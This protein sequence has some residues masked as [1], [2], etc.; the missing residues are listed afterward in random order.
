MNIYDHDPAKGGKLIKSFTGCRTVGSP[1][2][3]DVDGSGLF[4]RVSTEVAFGLDAD[5]E[6]ETLTE[7]F[8]PTEGILIDTRIGDELTGADLFGDQGGPWADGY[9][10]LARL[11]ANADGWVDGAALERPALWIDANGNVKTQ[12]RRGV[13]AGGARRVCPVQDP[14][15]FRLDR[16]VDRWIEHGTED[17]RLSISTPVGAQATSLRQAGLLAGAA[18]AI[19]AFGPV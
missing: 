8:A 18:L 7:W 12:P 5:G 10:K 19:L 15:R 2:A 6:A 13:G 4:E 11:D 1:M 14:R 17:H 3:L 16:P 9:A